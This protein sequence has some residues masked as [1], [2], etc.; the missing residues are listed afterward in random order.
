[1]SDY[2]MMKYVNRFKSITT[3]DSNQGSRNDQS[4]IYDFSHEISS[5][6]LMMFPQLKQPKFMYSQIIA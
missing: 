5:F 1:M 6:C 3:V 2:N 4:L